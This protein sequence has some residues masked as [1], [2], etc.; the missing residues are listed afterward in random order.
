MIVN[1]NTVF[2][3]SYDVVVLGFGGAG[4]TAARFAADNGAKVLIVDSAP[5]GH[6]GGNTRYSG[7]MVGYSTDEAAYRQ[8]FHGLAQ[9]FNLDEDLSEVFIKGVAGMKDYFEKYLDVDHVYSLKQDIMGKAEDD[10][11][12]DYPE[13][14]GAKNY[15]MIMV[16][17]GIVDGALWNTLRQKVLD[18]SDKI[19]VWYSSPVEHLIQTANQTVVGAQVKRDDTLINVYAKNG[20]VLATGGFENNQQMIQDYIGDYQLVPG[21]SLYNKGRGVDLATEAGAKLWHMTKF[22]GG[23]MQQ[24]F[25]L[26]EPNQKRA[27]TFRNIP[28]FCQGSIFTVGDDGARYFNE[29]LASHEGYVKM[30]GSYYTPVNPTHPYL[31]FDEKQKQKIAALKDEPYNKAL[32]HV[33]EA[34]S[35]SELADKMGASAKVLEDTVADFNFFAKE[36]MDYAYHRDGKTITAFAENGPYYAIPLVQVIGWTQGGPKRNS[37]CEIVS[38]IDDQPI[39]HL[40]GA[41]ELGS[42]ITNLYQGG[43]NLANCLI[44]GKI[45]GENAARPKADVAD[46]TSVEAAKLTIK[47]AKLGSDLQE[48]EYP[49]GKDQYIGRSSQGMG[50]EIVVRV[51]ADHDNIKQVEVL[52]QT[53]SDD[54][55]LQAIKELPAKMV[56]NNSYEVDAISGASS[57][58][59]GLK[60]AVKDA[61]SKL[62]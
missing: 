50:N 6:E 40:Y 46:T 2:D 53:E 11:M 34:D 28:E 62:N 56:E 37:N 41:G 1:K 42:V 14:P 61:L 27:K 32:D 36:G 10:I 4:A 31:V 5:E 59:R 26:W 45:A 43:S 38:A 15:D 51:T 13:F 58:S 35:L 48:D 33:V 23:G 16:H 47:S 21:A 24:I 25:S 30:A 17:K 3:T 49:T 18:R 39:P 9:K 54:Y 8:Y 44:F 57:T 60:D 22:S 19:D 52:K 55:G 20:V 12:A 29:E 7:Q